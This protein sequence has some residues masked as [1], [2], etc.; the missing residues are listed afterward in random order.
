MW[1]L[2]REHN[3]YDQHGS[4]YVMAWT[5]C[6]STLDVTNAIGTKEYTFDAEHIVMN[7]GGRQLPYREHDVWFNLFE[8]TR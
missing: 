6:P 1:I 2:T 7:G 4:Y 3:D 8:E 5:Y